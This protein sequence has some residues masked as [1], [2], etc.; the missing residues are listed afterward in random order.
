MSNLTDRERRGALAVSIA[1]YNEWMLKAEANGWKIP[2]NSPLPTH[3]W[4]HYWKWCDAY[5]RGL[6]KGRPVVP[7]V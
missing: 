7:H 1:E 6:T 2:G 4:V 5:R 3:S